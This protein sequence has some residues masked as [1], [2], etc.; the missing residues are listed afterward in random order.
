MKGINQF[1]NKSF[2][3]LTTMSRLVHFKAKLFLGG[4]LRAS[5]TGALRQAHCA[6]YSKSCLRRIS[7]I[8]ERLAHLKDQT[9]L[10]GVLHACL[11]MALR[12]LQ[13]F[14]RS[15]RVNFLLLQ[16]PSR[17][18]QLGVLPDGRLTERRER[19]MILLQTNCFFLYESVTL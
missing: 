14:R 7:V 10:S 17:R 8:I 15:H 9:F 6:L 19:M 2:L 16:R 12:L 4:V 5:L 1:Y 3:S 11:A 13:L 18:I